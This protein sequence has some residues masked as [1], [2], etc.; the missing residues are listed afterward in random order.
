VKRLCSM[1]VKG[2]WELPE[3]VEKVGNDMVLP[4]IK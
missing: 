3:N 4:A 2:H 1:S